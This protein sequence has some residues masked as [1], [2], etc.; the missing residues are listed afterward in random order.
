MA[1]NTL[2]NLQNEDTTLS[3]N[4]DTSYGSNTIP[5]SKSALAT[6]TSLSSVDKAI[7]T[8][9]STQLR[10]EWYGPNAAGS[11]TNSDTQPPESGF[12]M[13]TLKALQ[14]PENAVMGAIQY[15]LGKGTQPTLGANVN[16][17]MGTGLT[18]GNILQ[19]EGINNRAVQ[20]PLGFALDVMFD[21]V[22]WVTAGTDALIPRIGTG[23]VRGAMAK[24]AVEGAEDIAREAA[25]SGI[26]GSLKGGLT[27][28]TS[29]VSRT[30]SN[31][32]RAV[33]GINK[34]SS[35]EPAVAAEGETLGLGQNIRTALC[36]AD[37]TKLR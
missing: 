33:P 12:W 3:N 8:L 26:E 4:L 37:H 18:A 2:A 32:M 17:A 28:F 36:L 15:G 5:P 29:G 27:G 25:P 13:N 22:N 9:R 24:G 7:D 14:K 23:L 19:Q 11:D 20:I 1:D 6:D 10:N 30:A 34:L 16:A 35:L 21:P 31:V